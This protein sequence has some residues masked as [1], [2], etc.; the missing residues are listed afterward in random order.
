LSLITKQFSIK[1]I[2]SW[3]LLLAKIE[4]IYPAPENL[5][6]IA[7]VKRLVLAHAGIKL[8]QILC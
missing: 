8:R 5:S 6:L 3:K 1:R 4:N 7:E 2:E